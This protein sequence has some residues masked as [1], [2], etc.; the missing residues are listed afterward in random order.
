MS[1]FGSVGKEIV[2]P[3]RNFHSFMNPQEAYQEAQKLAQHGYNTAKDIEQPFI[4]QGQAQYDPLNQAR[5][6]LMNPAELQNQWAQSYQESPY[7]KQM[8][9]LNRQSGL[10]T[11]GSMGLMGSSAALNNIQQGAGNIVNQDRQQFL[12]DLMQKY[13]AGIGLGQNLYGTGANMAGQ[14]GNQ[15]MQHG[16]NMA[17]LGY[18]ANASQGKLF[19]NLLRLA[20]KLSMGGGAGSFNA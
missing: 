16:Q 6:A 9:D 7:A 12:N 5:T 10:E 2:Q 20:G 13:M 3:F 17:S 1:F 19:E 11:A 15:A 18:G 8:L 14:L 4:N